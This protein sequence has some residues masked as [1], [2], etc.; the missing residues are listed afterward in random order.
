MLCPTVPTVVSLPLASFPSPLLLTA[1]Q[2][3]EDLRAAAGGG[4]GDEDGDE[5]DGG[6]FRTGAAVDEEVDEKLRLD[7]LEVSVWH[8]SH[9][10]LLP[11]I[12]GVVQQHQERTLTT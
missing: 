11:W 7:A 2:Y 6:D 1:R 12:R 3:L 8:V 9:A 4:A 10:D 5:G